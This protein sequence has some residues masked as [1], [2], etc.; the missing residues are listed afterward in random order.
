MALIII[1]NSYNY[2]NHLKLNLINKTAPV[3]IDQDQKDKIL[4]INI[5]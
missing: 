2:A 1:P 3:L 4:E 5:L